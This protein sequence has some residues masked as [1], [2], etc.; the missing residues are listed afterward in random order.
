M[1]RELVFSRWLEGWRV[2]QAGARGGMDASSA[3]GRCAMASWW[4]VWSL[5]AAARSGN[6][7]SVSSGRRVQVLHA[8]PGEDAGCR[9]VGGSQENR[10]LSGGGWVGR[11]WCCWRVRGR[12]AACRGGARAGCARVN[13]G[14]ARWARHEVE[15]QRRG[16]KEG[17]RGIEKTLCALVCDRLEMGWYN[18][19]GDAFALAGWCG[20]KARGPCGLAHRR[21]P[22]GRP[23]AWH[24]NRCT[25]RG[26]ARP[27]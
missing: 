7:T 10:R 8:R 22:A 11:G 13:G 4:V 19:G 23:L 27:A 18:M 16:Q 3:G 9:G 20:R 15:I 1:R 2:L 26:P 24:A 5:A 6:C 17:D 14:L 21:H 25:A 12:F